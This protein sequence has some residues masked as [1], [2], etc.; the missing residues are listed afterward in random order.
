MATIEQNGWADSAE[1]WIR[2]VDEGDPSRSLILDPPM[3]ALFEGAAGEYVLDVGCGEGRFCRMLSTLGMRTTGIDP[4]GRLLEEARLRHP[5]GAYVEGSAEDMPFESASF[6]R[7]VSYVSLVDIPDHRAAIREMARVL[8]PGGLLVVANLN[9][10]VTA[11]PWGW[12]RDEDGSPMHYPLDEYGFEHAEWVS[13]KGIKILNWHRPLSEY[14]AAFLAE[15]LILK[16]YAEPH[17]SADALARDPSL[18][19]D[20]R[21]PLFNIAVWRKP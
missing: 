17:P 9:S 1:A 20:I 10:F 5:E 21:V 15:N 2:A 6:D 18:H 16:S 19:K 13:W 12:I 14:M 11:Q 7:V 4:T 8:R 3:L